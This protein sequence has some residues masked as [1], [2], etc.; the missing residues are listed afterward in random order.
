MS[1][2]TTLN[3]QPQAPEQTP[4]KAKKAKQE[5][6]LYA[7]ADEAKQHQ[8]TTT[9][10]FPRRLFRVTAP[11]GKTAFVW[12]RGHDHAFYV[13]A[14]KAGWKAASAEKA[15]ATKE[16]VAAALAELSPED[17][18]ALLAQLQGETGKGRKG[19]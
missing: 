13:V 7:T 1:E 5:V 3:S 11:D 12:A 16:S 2:Q 8:P 4:A 19:K 18:A 10:K 14:A 9:S 15:P 6:V 17:K